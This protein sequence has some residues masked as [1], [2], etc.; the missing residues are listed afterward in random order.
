MK[1]F[2]KIRASL[3]L[4]EAIRQANK[5]HAET[6]HRYYVMPART[7][8]GTPRLLIMDRSNFRKLKQKRY[9][10]HNAYI[11]DL[12]KEC[13]YCTPYKELPYPKVRMDRGLLTDEE[14]KA[15]RQAYFHWLGL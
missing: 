9:I 11:H 13:F 5:A 8:R 10:T 15:K 1:L 4:W 12:E 6:G 2:K 14:I 3:R 7:K